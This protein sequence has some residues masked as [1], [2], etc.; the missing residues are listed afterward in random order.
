M[1]DILKDLHGHDIDK[2]DFHFNRPCSLG[3]INN[4]L[5]RNQSTKK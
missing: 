2:Q 1:L 3:G 4:Y 5:G